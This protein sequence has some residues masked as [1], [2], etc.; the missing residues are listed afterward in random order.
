MTVVVSLSVSHF[1][2]TTQAQLLVLSLL[3]GTD[4]PIE[5]CMLE[6]SSMPIFRKQI[7]FN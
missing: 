5:T 6:L 2:E 1:K 3:A 4:D 7:T